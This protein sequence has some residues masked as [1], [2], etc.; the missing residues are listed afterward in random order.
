MTTLN[1]ILIDKRVS[2]YE[3]IVAAV[4]PALAIGIVFDYYEDTFD[5]VKTRMRELVEVGN[6][7]PIAICL[8][9][10]N[11]NAPMFTMLASADVAPV[12][13][14]STQDPDLTA[15]TQ[16]RDLITWCKTEFNAAYFDMMAC[17]LYSDPDWKY[18]IDTLTAQTGVTVRAST[19]DTG[20]ASLGGDWF[21][22]S[23]TG[24]NLKTVYFT[25]AI[26]EYH[27]LLLRLSY[28]GTKYIKTYDFKGI[29]TGSVITW[30]PPSSF[31]VFGFGGGG[32]SSSVSSSIQSD[33]ISIYSAGYAHAALKSDGSV[34]AWGDTRYGGNYTSVASSLT[35]GVVSIY[36]TQ[37]AF[38]ALKSNGSVVAWGDQNYGGEFS[39]QYRFPSPD[40]LDSGVVAV[41]STEAAFAALKSD[42]SVQAWGNNTGGWL[43]N[44]DTVAYNLMRSG[45]VS[46]YSSQYAFVA[47][48]SNGGLVMWGGAGW[49]IADVSSSIS[50]GVVAVYSTQYA[51]AA[52]KND[53]SVI[54]WADQNFGGNS[55]V[56]NNTTNTYT[57]VASSLTSGFVSLWS[58]QHAF[59]ALK[60]D[61][62]V[63]TWGWGS[64]GGNSSSVSSSL[65]SG[66]VAVYSTATAFA[67]LKNDGSVITW[68]GGANGGNSSSV[69][70]SL[71]S[72]VVAIYSTPAA[73]AALK[74][75][76]SIVAWG[77]NG[78]GGSFPDLVDNSGFV[79]IYSTG[80]AF[81]AL[82]SNG[83]VITWGGNGGDST[84]VSSSLNSGVIGLTSNYYSFAA[85]KTSASTFDL[86][87]SVYTD[88]DRYT[89]LRNKESRRRVNLTTL[90]NNVFTLSSSRD[91]QVINPNIPAGKTFKIIIPTYVAS[92]YSITSDAVIP[93][94]SG[95]FIV[96]CDESESVTI[97]GT[98]YVNYGAFV[99]QV[100]ANGTY[101]KVTSAT[102]NGTTYTLYGGDGVF[103][104]GIVF[105]E[106]ILEVS[107]LSASTFTVAPSKTFGNAPFSF[108][109]LPTSNNS[110]VAIVYSS[111]NTN[112]ATV[113]ASGTT[114]TLVGAGDVSFNA[115]QTQTNQ[116]AAATK[117]SNTLTVSRATSTLSGTFA[118]PSSKTFGN[119]PFSFDTL[120]T[121]NNSSVAIVY[122][123]RN[124]NVATVDASGTTITLVGAGDVSFNATQLQ[125]N[126]YNAPTPVMSNTL[127]VSK[128]TP[129]LMFVSPPT[130]KSL[131]DAA[132]TVT[133][134]SGILFSVSNSGSGAYVINSSSNP[135]LTVIRGMRYILSVNASGHPFWIQTVSGAYSSGNIYSNSSIVNNGE[136]VGTIV[137]EVALDTPNTLYYACQFHSS[138]QGTINVADGIGPT[139]ASSGAVTY[140]S[141]NTDRATVGLTTGLV[142][143]LD[144]GSVTITAAQAASAQYNAPTNTTFAITIGAAAN[145]IGQTV[146]TSLA[147]KNLT[148]ASFANTVLTNV[149]LTGATLSGVNFSGATIT[150]AN[151]TNA[152][153]VGATNLPVFSTTQ[154]LQLLRN[155]NNV[156]ISAVQISAPISGADL[157]AAISNPLPEIAAATFVVKAPAYNANSEKV[158]TISTADVSGNASIYIPLNDNETVKIN[159]AAYTFNGTNVLDA[160]NN[161]ITF[162]T[163]LNKPFRLYA[164][165]IIGLNV[166]EKMNNVRFVDSGFYDILSEFFVFKN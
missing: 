160:S 45:V 54:T 109:A 128:V 127:T 62:S 106:L 31:L 117:T 140:T 51:W 20:A 18:V 2:Q 87:G 70:S 21:L 131:T 79:S 166:V 156:A 110:S 40:I 162:L 107:T 29:A 121:S 52:L 94:S 126:Q 80:D 41:Y 61:G 136:D 32:N 36:S 30:G 22:E 65:T 76:G 56:Y 133:A 44:Y 132:F 130:T 123:S 71:T 26:E 105:L 47:L 11:Y 157:N 59:A 97:S 1:I 118:V 91:I 75:N 83:S 125:T 78:Y 161:V 146:T 10:H 101:T 96:A 112:V 38:A 102:I 88:M 50:S 15:W 90:N 34:V 155:T 89:I 55:S 165:S 119:A 145:L 43:Y 143:L 64:Y 95:S 9:Q 93:N 120:P 114:I 23:H 48:K 139:G 154:K 150:G 16:F 138:M 49:T 4:D 53:G 141:S 85:L 63:V 39:S 33:V 148:G 122:S 7:I 115:T 124:T 46:I 6:S 3:D 151:F 60:N 28:V 116:Y 134:T 129:T 99:Y 66:V 42:G 158:V 103:S 13:Q 113:D 149:S 147:R 98:T 159:G 92:S 108:N 163:V 82:K 35:S 27:G 58:N 17:A 104:S 69:S 8:I 81:A 67:A 84:S 74:S 5:T 25:E 142:T 144:T 73:F 12:A 153:I 137:W 135:T 68:G 111:R 37:R 24:V 72:G 86:S 77:H 19:D 14:V 57:S 152:N 100:N 164:G